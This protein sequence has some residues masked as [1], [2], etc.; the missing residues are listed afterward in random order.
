MSDADRRARSFVASLPAGAAI[1]D[2]RSLPPLLAARLEQAK[3]ARPGVVADEERFIAR[4]A[5]SI[6]EG[7]DVAAALAKLHVGDLWLAC[8]CE[9][10]DGA[11]IAAFEAEFHGTVRSALSRAH[12][13]REELEDAVQAMREKLLVG[14]DGS[15]PRISQYAGRGPLLAWVA[16]AATRTARS[17]TRKVTREA[18]AS[19]QTVFDRASAGD[20]PGLALVKQRYKAE[21]KIA[22]EQAFA[23][24]T[25]RERNLLRLQYVDGLNVDGLA[26]VY[27]VHRATAARWA[28]AARDEL[29]AKTRDAL[30]RAIRV[31]RAE[32]ESIA[33]AV[34]SQLDVSLQGLFRSE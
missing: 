3:A 33:R 30:E 13:T 8:A 17:A 19:D 4:L 25:A 5:G 21:F 10:G 12:R 2:E 18:P 23:E 24:L 7:D 22:F 14:G 26:A 31:D 28:R 1:A 34:Q 11:A 20:D 15:A 9:A 16:V 32:F 6:Q 27:G 29:F